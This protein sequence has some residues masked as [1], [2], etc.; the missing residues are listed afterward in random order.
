MPKKYLRVDASAVFTGATLAYSKS[1]VDDYSTEIE[2]ANGHCSGTQ[3]WPMTPGYKFGYFGGG[4]NAPA[5]VFTPNSGN[6]L[7]GFIWKELTEILTERVYPQ[8]DADHLWSVSMLFKSIALGNGTTAQVVV[9]PYVVKMVNG[10]LV[11]T[12]FGDS[13][14]ADLTAGS[15]VAVVASGFLAADRNLADGESLAMCVNIKTVAGGGGGFAGDDINAKLYLGDTGG[16]SAWTIDEV[17]LSFKTDVSMSGILSTVTPVQH[18]VAVVSKYSVGIS[19]TGNLLA[20]TI[21]NMAARV[22]M[23]STFS[24][25]GLPNVLGKLAAGIR[26]ASNFFGDVTHSL[27]PKFGFRMTFDPSV[28][29]LVATSPKFGF[30]MGL[31]I[32]PTRA[33]TFWR[34]VRTPYPAVWRDRRNAV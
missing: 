15:D 17:Q 16:I 33:G 5:V 1:T 26:V 14:S 6:T 3:Y 30:K 11:I 2:V 8:G 27:A 12:P 10:S 7:Y 23:N 4:P 31:D 28:N 29:P 34:D 19:A 22:G 9:A 20:D 21:T 24:V 13:F 25:I 18:G 32:T